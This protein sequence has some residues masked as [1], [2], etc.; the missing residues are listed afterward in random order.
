[1]S[2]A[3]SLQ[4]LVELAHQYWP[5]NLVS[6]DDI[7]YVTSGEI[8]RQTAL[9]EAALKDS[10]Q[11]N[12]LLEQL[13]QTLPGCEPWELPYLLHEP[14]RYVRIS[15][16]GQ[17]LTKGAGELTELA[18]MV[19]V[20]APVYALF[21]SRQRY[22]D[23]RMVWNE[24]YFPPLPAE[25]QPREATLARLIEAQLGC[26]RLANDVLFTPVPDLKVQ[27]LRLGEARLIDCLFSTNR[28]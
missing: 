9:R 25:F 18:A 21:G 3:P 23:E 24:L 28:W 5:A 16:P 10:S 1:M 4:A 14:C 11:W 20:L 19:S 17:G 27:H 12:A 26:T 15:V 8:Q 22:E 7:R 13:G 6:S 2:Q